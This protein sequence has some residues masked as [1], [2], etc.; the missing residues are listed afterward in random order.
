MHPYHLIICMHR[1]CTP[2]THPHL[3]SISLA[4][5]TLGMWSLCRLQY[6]VVTLHSYK[7]EQQ[8]SKEGWTPQAHPLSHSESCASHIK[9]YC[10]H[11][12]C[13]YHRLGLLYL[14]L[15]RPFVLVVVAISLVP[16][17][18]SPASCVQTCSLGLPFQEIR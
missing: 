2:C 3:M 8:C 18:K 7:R 17:L 6:I 1:C 5:T 14:S 11:A 10:S 15:L 4:N 13:L 12:C 16:S 9:S